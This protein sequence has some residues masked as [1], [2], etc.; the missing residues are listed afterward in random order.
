MNESDRWTKPSRPRA[1]RT[2]GQDYHVSFSHR[3]PVFDPPLTRR[4]RILYWLGDRIVAA[5]HRLHRMADR[6]L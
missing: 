6:G 1:M 5:G 4:Q 2:G 3:V